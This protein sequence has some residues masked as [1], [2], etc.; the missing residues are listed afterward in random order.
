MA[1]YLVGIDLGGTNVNVGC[2]DET[3]K[4][5]TK[6]SLALGKPKTR[7]EVL[8]SI[9]GATEETLKRAGLKAEQV[10]A[11]GIATP[12]TLDI[13]RGVVVFA[14]NLPEWEDVPLRDLIKMFPRRLG[15]VLEND[16]NAAAWGEYW[17]GVGKETRLADGRHV[18]SLVMLT[19]GTGI[20]GGVVLDGKVWHGFKDAAAEL[21]H[22]TIDFRGRP[23]PCGNIGCL[24][25]YA[26]ADSTV[27]RFLEAVKSGA[28]TNWER[29][30]RE[31]PEEVTSRRIHEEALKGDVLS[32]KTIEE[33]GFYLGVGIVSIL[34]FLNPQMVVL[35]GG[36]TG[37]GSMLMDPLMRVVQERALGRS[38]E[39]VKIVFARLGVDA[40]FIGA[41][42][43]ALT[44]L[45]TSA[46]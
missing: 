10:R 36:L 25:A 32:R 34:H 38:R 44:A 19:L 30:V 28:A 40:G 12:G 31:H 27:R 2:V 21:G 9:Y 41:A 43:C 7:K 17:A 24:E 29:A 26:S 5:I 22:I 4:V 45:E 46:S 14:A 3:G 13:A 8:E 16:A 33:T 42:G 18:S 39:D 1:E 20:G 23:C 6:H 15:T 11:V 35:T 37:A